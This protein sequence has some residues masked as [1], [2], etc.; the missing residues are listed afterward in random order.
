MFRLPFF[1]RKKL[2]LAFEYG[3]IL[4]KTAQDMKIEMTPELVA[5]A[6]EM[7]VNEAKNQSATVMATWMVPNILSVFEIDTTK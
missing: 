7:L 2:L 4:A 1:G 5:K 6:E 3:L